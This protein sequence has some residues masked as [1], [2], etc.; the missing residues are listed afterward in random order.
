[1]KITAIAPSHN[2]P[3]R[4]WLSVDN[5][6][7]GY[8]TAEDIFE[9]G[10]AL[11]RAMTKQTYSKLVNRI[12]YNQHYFAA[13]AYADRRLRSKA[14][15]KH[16]LRRRGCALDNTNAII[17]K[18]EQLGIID[19]T[20][21]AD[22]FVHDALTLKPLS[23]RML[24]LKLKTKQLDPKVI[25]QS[26]SAVGYDD[27]TALEQLVRQKQARYAG[28]QDRFF[29]YLLRQGFAYSDIVKAIGKPEFRRRP[30]VR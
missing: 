16:Y 21:L 5:K 29:R 11:G 13:T 6:P 30:P 9:L 7:L 14:E 2:R 20:K 3:G 1:M 17:Q 18:L 27:N 25:K 26:I 23:S 15:V 19:E 8:V 22:A 24:A 10:L 28:E 12:T 4:Y